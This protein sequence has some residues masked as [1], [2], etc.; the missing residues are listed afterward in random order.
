MSCQPQALEDAGERGVKVQEGTDKAQGGDKVAGKGAVK[1]SGACPSSQEHKAD[2]TAA[3]HEGAVF[4]GTD[5]GVPHCIH[6]AQGIALGDHGEEHHGDGAGEGVWKE[7]K[8]HCHAGEHTVNA[9]GGDGIVAVEPEP[10]GDGY[11]F[12][13][14]QKVQHDTVRSQGERHGQEAAVGNFLYAVDGHGRRCF[15]DTVGKHCQ[16]R[17]GHGKEF[18]YT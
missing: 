14:L 1:Q 3:A 17:H 15:T 16:R 12:H 13:A 6:V 10:C 2:H 7:D 18:P 5:R 4:D 9:Q 11:G 8:G